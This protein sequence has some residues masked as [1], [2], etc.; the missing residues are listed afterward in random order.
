MKTANELKQEREK[1]IN[2]HNKEKELIEGQWKYIEGKIDQFEITKD[3]K[4]ID[5]GKIELYDENIVKLTVNNNF[6]IYSDNNKN[7]ILYFDRDDYNKMLAYGDS[8]QSNIY[9]SNKCSKQDKETTDNN[10]NSEQIENLKNNSKEQVKDD[11]KVETNK[12]NTNYN[13]KLKFSSFD[14]KDNYKKEY[15][16]FGEFIKDLEAM[17]IF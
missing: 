4:Y 5:L 9:N 10:I 17:Q 7:I 16:S 15:N 6:Y 14:G 1:L 12:N 2:E 8:V 11:K 13:F 3:S